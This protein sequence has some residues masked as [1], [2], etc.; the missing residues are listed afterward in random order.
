VDSPYH[1]R[2]TAFTENL[3]G[4]V[5][6]QAA[7]M[8]SGVSTPG[9]TWKDL[10]AVGRQKNLLPRV[11]PGPVEARPASRLSSRKLRRERWLA[12]RLARL[13]DRMERRRERLAVRWDKIARQRKRE[14]LAFRM[15]HRWYLLTE[16]VEPLIELLLIRWYRFVFHVAARWERTVLAVGLSAALAVTVIGLL[17]LGAAAPDFTNGSDTRSPSPDPSTGVSSEPDAVPSPV[18]PSDLPIYTNSVSGY[19][20]SY[21]NDWD[22]STSGTVAVLSDP[23]GQI[24]ISFYGAPPG[25]LQEASDR[26]VEE[27]GNSFGAPQTIATDVNRTSQGYPSMAVGGIASDDTGAQIRFLAITI[28]GPDENRAIMVLFPAEPD[29]LDLDALLGVVDSFKIAP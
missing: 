22:V 6:H 1:G 25:S 2:E 4:G 26:V 14:G 24:E 28:K 19:V 11:A 29:P 27:L 5:E 18:P 15:R 8:P 13:A 21:P 16:R 12:H 23:E 3:G 7:S 9:E 20:F 17:P 10:T